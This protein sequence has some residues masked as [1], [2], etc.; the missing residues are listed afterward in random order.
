MKFE[1]VDR[2]YGKSISNGRLLEQW[3]GMSRTV[4][5]DQEQAGNTI[6]AS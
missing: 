4:F 1:K 2:V 5:S 6:V 3:H